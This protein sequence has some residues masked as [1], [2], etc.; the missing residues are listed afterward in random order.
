[1]FKI[2]SMYS[3]IL[4]N[5]NDCLLPKHSNF[6]WRDEFSSVGCISLSSHC[7]LLQNQ[8]CMTE[9]WFIVNATC[10]K[11]WADIYIFFLFRD[12]TYTNFVHIQCIFEHILKDHRIMKTFLT[13]WTTE[14]CWTDRVITIVHPRKLGGALIISSERHCWLALVILFTIFTMPN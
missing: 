4:T 12:Y 10:K 7:S 6:H 5:S 13:Y 3:L 2:I 8:S 11:Y 9:S 14:S 1:M